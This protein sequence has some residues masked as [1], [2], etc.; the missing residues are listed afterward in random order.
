METHLIATLHLGAELG[1]YLSVHGHYTG[2]DEIV[3]LAARAHTGIGQ[4]LVQADRLVGVAQLLAILYLFLLAVFLVAKAVSFGL[5]AT[6]KGWTLAT[7]TEPLAT[8]TVEAGARSVAFT[9]LAIVGG[10]EGILCIGVPCVARLGTAVLRTTA[11]GLVG[12]VI[13]AVVIAIVAVAAAI[14]ALTVVST[15]III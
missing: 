6:A 7:G 5:E 2:R 8:L 15:F 11:I 10:A 1:H 9:P 12:T 4:V 14:G 13:V 3:G